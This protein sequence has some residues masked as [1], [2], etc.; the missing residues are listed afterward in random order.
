[1]IYA[2]GDIHGCLNHLINLLNLVSP[3]LERHQ[4]VFVGDYVDRGPHSSEVVEYIIDLKKKY[5]PEN[6]ICLMG[7]HERMFLDFLQG[8]EEMFFLMNGGASTAVSYWGDQWERRERRLPSGHEHFFE[9][10]KL[11]YETDDYIFVHGGL[12]PGLPLAA[13]KEEDLLWIRKDF[14]LSEFDFGR[15]VIF[16]HTPVRTPLVRP[17]KIGIDTGAV[18]GN[19]LTCVLLPEE[20]FFSVSK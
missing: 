7:N 13:Q 3:D 4:L 10:L 6:I 12:R 20:K 16:G 18:Y 19:N 15:R 8:R 14:I 17:N 9:T 11:Y 2:I 5:N 1:M